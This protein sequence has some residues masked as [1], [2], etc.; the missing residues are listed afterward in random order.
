MKI[1]DNISAI[2]LSLLFLTLGTFF[3]RMNIKLADPKDIQELIIKVKETKSYLDDE[4]LES[5]LLSS[6]NPT[7]GQI[8]HL[9]HKINN[10]VS[11]E[12]SRTAKT[13]TT[14]LSELEKN[15]YHPK[16]GIFTFN[17]ISD[18]QSEEPKGVVLRTLVYG[19][20]SLLFLFLMLKLKRR[21]LGSV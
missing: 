19:T 4:A 1:F 20:I 13:D 8:D 10:Q 12:L 2:L 5:L 7:V 21:I 14:L 15:K 3:L 17:F 16:D 9:K 18:M 6:S 11:V